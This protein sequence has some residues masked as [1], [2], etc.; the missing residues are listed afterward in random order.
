MN[1]KYIKLELFIRKN[2]FTLFE[3]MKS[4]SVVAF[5]GFLSIKNGMAGYLLVKVEEDGGKNLPSGP[6]ILPA[7]QMGKDPLIQDPS[8]NPRKKLVQ[9]CCEDSGVPAM[10]LGLCTTPESLSARQLSSRWESAC[11]RFDYMIEMCQFGPYEEKDPIPDKGIILRVNK[12]F[13]PLKITNIVITD[14]FTLLEC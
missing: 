13:V 7:T 8:S 4:F 11:K 9:S 6:V 10:C 3:G 2:F 1:L 12:D 5:I 14:S